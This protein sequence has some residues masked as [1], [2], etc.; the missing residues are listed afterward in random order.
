VTCQNAGKKVLLSLGGDPTNAPYQL[1]SAQ[2][3]Y[4]LAEFLWSAFGPAN[5]S[6]TGPRP[7]DYNGV[8]NVVDGFDF[9]IEA[10]T[11]GLSTRVV[12]NSI[13]DEDIR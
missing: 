10:I 11:T 2:D 6:W 8:V 7:F 4:D 12:K 5:A 3:G 13:A 9:D 1:T